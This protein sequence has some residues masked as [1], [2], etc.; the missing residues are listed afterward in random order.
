MPPEKFKT[1][2]V[3]EETF[4]KLIARRNMLNKE[5]VEKVLQLQNYKTDVI[6]LDTTLNFLDDK[7]E[8]SLK[9]TIINIP[10]IQAG[11]TDTIAYPY[12][13]YHGITYITSP[14]GSISTTTVTDSNIAA[15]PNLASG[16]TTNAIPLNGI[17]HT[18]IIANTTSNNISDILISNAL[19]PD[20][21][22][23]IPVRCTCISSMSRTP[24]HFEGEQVGNCN[25]CSHSSDRHTENG[26]LVRIRYNK[27][28]EE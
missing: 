12:Y 3:S 8:Q 13:P 25:I 16:A 18:N 26:C 1:I 28:N 11:S 7:F 6:S 23:S 17:T 24:W 19:R 20:K 10:Q 22:Q 9:S 5:L 4:N 21:Q 14:N 15:G 27:T 2:T